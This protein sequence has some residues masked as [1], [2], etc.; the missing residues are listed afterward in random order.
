[1]VDHR[2]YGMEPASEV[3]RVQACGRGHASLVLLAA[4]P[5]AQLAPGLRVMVHDAVIEAPAIV[6]AAEDPGPPVPLGPLVPARDAR[7]IRDLL[8]T[9]GVRAAVARAGT[10]ARVVT[11][12]GSAPVEI[13]EAVEQTADFAGRAGVPGETLTGLTAVLR[14][15]AANA[16]QHGNHGD[17]ARRVRIDLVIHGGALALAV[18]DEGTGFDHEAV[19]RDLAAARDA[20]EL[21]AERAA[22]GGRGGLGLLMV[23]R[24]ADRVSW[25]AG[26]RRI[27]I[28]KRFA[29]APAGDEA[30]RLEDAPG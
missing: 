9:R 3:A 30:L 18:E 6:A 25:S 1:M 27:A 12:S 2:E 26:G 5:A 13:A 23:R 20:L 29:A 7:R 24:W 15:T 17:P 28:E 22:S 14:E 11:A 4:P 8:A 16:A 21:A 19:A 10:W